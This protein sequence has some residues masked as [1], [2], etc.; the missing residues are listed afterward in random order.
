MVMAGREP[1]R[2]MQVEVKGE[3]D[4]IVLVPGRLTGW[5][6]WRPHAEKLAAGH[7]VVLVQLLAVEMGLNDEPLP[8]D[9]SVQTEVS[10]L[11]AA[12]DGIELEKADFAAWSFGAMT[13]LSFAIHN[14]GRVRSLT[15]IEP[16]A[17]WVL[18]SRGPLSDEMLAQQKQLQSLGPGDVSE[19]QLAW[20]TH[21]AGFVPPEV[22]SSK[23][24][25]WPAWVEHRQ[26]LRNGDAAYRHEDDIE[27]VREF[28]RPVLLFKGEG[29]SAFLNQVIDILGEE[30]PEATV[31]SLP[32]GHALHIIS[33][34][35]F[36]ETLEGFLM[37]VH[38]NA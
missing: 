19:E 35:S 34:D 18:R 23:L 7:K 38:A 11:E 27:L 32:G 31:V 3:G 17:I 1:A 37:R 16:P 30:F 24:P 5:M 26:S 8:P 33:M 10:A 4:P 29:S 28:D 14:P 21:F 13:T 12:L 22:D 20:F 36:M 9:Y 6:S 25:T 15:L 2:A